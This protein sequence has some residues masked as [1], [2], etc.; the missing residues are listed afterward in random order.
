MFSSKDKVIELRSLNFDFINKKVKHAGISGK[1]IIFFGA[2]W[3]G[4]CVRTAPEYAKAADALGSGFSMFYLNC[5]KYPKVGEL[6]NINGYP[7]IM[8]LKDGKQYKMYKGERTK[9]GFIKE[10]CK[11]AMK[12]V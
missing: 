1:S 11:E 5:E 10:V 2:P 12:C 8:F 6:M 3:C 9:E 7:T 4:H